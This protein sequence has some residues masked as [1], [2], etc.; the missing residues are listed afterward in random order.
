M[1]ESNTDFTYLSVLREL[2]KEVAQLA[3]KDAT[4]PGASLTRT[5]AWFKGTV[6]GLLSFA[7]GKIAGGSKVIAK[8]LG[9]TSQAI[10]ESEAVRLRHL[11]AW[12]QNQSRYEVGRATTWPPLIPI[13]LTVERFVGTAI[14]LHSESPD[15][16]FEH[17]VQSSLADAVAPALAWGLWCQMRTS[18]EEIRPHA[19]E[20]I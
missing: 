4:D 12:T 20:A 19:I 17:H 15:E 18:A 6:G 11:S 2:E 8:S 7:T 9:V 1:P 13:G 3:G 14:G 5:N 10:K 16:P